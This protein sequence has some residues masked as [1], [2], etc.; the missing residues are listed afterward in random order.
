MAGE[1]RSP[2]HARLQLTD[3]GRLLSGWLV[4]TL[5]LAVADELL[6]DFSASSVWSLAAV[7][8]VSGL[9]G[10]VV[11]PV[12]VELTVRVGWLTVL[13]LAFVAQGLV[14]HLAM[15]LVP[16]I[17]ATFAAAFLASWISAAAGTL[18]AYL[19]T[20]GTDASFIASLARRSRPRELEDGDVD[21]VVIV[22]LD[23]VPFPVLRWAVQAGGVPTIRRWVTSGAYQ[24]REWT[25]Q[26]PCTTPASQLGILHGTVAGI[27]GFRWYDRQLGRVLVANHPPDSRIIE[28][29]ASNGRGLL[30][31]DGVS[32]SNLFS[33][34]A[35]NALLTM[36]R[37]TDAPGS[38][39]TKRALAWFMLTPTG[40]AR[41]LT[42]TVG[43]VVKERWQARTQ[44]RQQLEPR[45]QRTWTFAVL[46]AVTNALLRDLNTALVAEE[47]LRGTKVIY[48]DYVDYDEIAHHAGIF[49]HESLAALEGLDR[50]LAQLAQLA[51]HTARRYRIVVLSDHGQSQGQPFA[52]RYGAPLSSVCSQLM[53]ESVAA[54]EESVESWGRAG[55]LVQDMGQEGLS[56]RVAAPAQRRLDHQ[57]RRE[58]GGRSPDDVVVLGSGNLG[59]LYV[60]GDTRLSLDELT[61][62]WPRLRPGL[63][64]H[65][66]V[67][68]V[69]G[70]DDDGVPWAYGRDGRCNLTTGAVTGSDPL[71]DFAPH[72]SRVLARAVLLPD[73]PDLYVNSSV[74]KDTLE[75]AAFEGLVGAHGGLGGWQDSGLLLVPRD[76]AQTMPE[77]V[78]GADELHQVLLRFLRSSGQ[79]QDSAAAAG[80][81]RP[82]LPL[83]E[84]E[85][86]ALGRDVGNG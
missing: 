26:L 11:R 9:V 58:E 71:R 83:R 51:E 42:R 76:L 29:R 6:P 2:T 7:A 18:V 82:G 17:T 84:A 40:F 74:D 64:E 31:E 25:P 55:S 35:P 67:G 63:C 19:A 37:A 39:Q 30:C 56:G 15:V 5:T 59:L 1:A 66:G 53:I 57:L 12:L 65:P 4:S 22:Q 16:G 41:S 47:M 70:I 33:G 49:R 3:A 23:G 28:A 86:P 52:D 78:E 54:Y 46:R 34:D 48:A 44:V 85:H 24:L 27:P 62:R 50:V 68:F 38:A 72:A 10:L 36:S 43:E 61:R 21:G 45:V 13:P 80:R 60:P 77:H 69:A 20:A 81:R 75:I 73:A 79:R 32:I 14:M 8:A